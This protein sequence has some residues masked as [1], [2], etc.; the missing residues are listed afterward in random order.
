MNLIE[1]LQRAI[2]AELEGH[3]FYMMAAQSTSD[4]QGKQVFQTLSNEE[5]DHAN[6]LKGQMKAI[7]ATGKPDLGLSLGPKLDLAGG[8]PIFSESIKARLGAAHI[9][10]SA[11]AIGIQ[12]ELDAMN[13]YKAQSEAAT[14][15]EVSRFFDVLAE[16]E[17]GHYHALL[18]QE[19]SLKEDYW[20]QSGFAPF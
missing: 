6:F 8:F 14:D 17:A 2:K 5:M 18:R 1:A 19:E 4:K 10:M 20:S 16:W 13:F 12:L 15:L 11:L 7:S 9:E 3:S